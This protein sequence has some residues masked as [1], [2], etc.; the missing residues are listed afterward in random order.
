MGQRRIQLS[1][2]S[3]GF[4]A[5]NKWT[6]C[7]RCTVQTPKDEFFYY[8]FSDASDIRKFGIKLQTGGRCTRIRV[9]GHLFGI[10][11]SHFVMRINNFSCISRG[12]SLKRTWREGINHFVRSQVGCRANPR[13]P[14]NYLRNFCLVFLSFF[15]I[16]VWIQLGDHFGH[17][18]RR[19]RTRVGFKV[20]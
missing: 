1:F 9:A 13:K 17:V 12:W 11:G 19:N 15:M 2:S 18:M 10:G 20:C 7:C 14:G 6:S 5:L 16:H 3:V 4:G 8:F